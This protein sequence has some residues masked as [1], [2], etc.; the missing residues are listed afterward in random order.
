MKEGSLLDER[1]KESLYWMK[2][3][4]FL[5][6]MKVAGVGVLVLDEGGVVV[7][8]L[9]EVRGVPVLVEGGCSCIR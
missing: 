1:R 6:W 2:V 5:Y 9:H 8:L 3:G 4:A 7:P